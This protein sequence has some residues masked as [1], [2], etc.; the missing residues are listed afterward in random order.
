MTICI[1]DALVFIFFRNYDKLSRSKG[2]VPTE[3]SYM[4]HKKY[5]STQCIK[6][7]NKVKASDRFTECQK[8]G[9]QK[10]SCKYR[11]MFYTK[12]NPSLSSLSFSESMIKTTL[13]SLQNVQRY[14]KW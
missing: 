11:D 5:S 1:V 13:L 4:Y 8:D 10:D 9:R 6:V 2:Y 12:K 14:Q 7:S 3:R